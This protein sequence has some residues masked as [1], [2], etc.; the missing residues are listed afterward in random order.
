M[1]RP[2][3]PLILIF[4]ALISLILSA[5]LKQTPVVHQD[6]HSTPAP[7]IH[8][9]LTDTA[10]EIQSMWAQLGRIEQ[11][12]DPGRITNLKEYPGGEV[13]EDLRQELTLE[14]WT[15]EIGVLAKALANKISYRYAELGNKPTQPLIVTITA[16]DQPVGEL[17]RVG[18]SGR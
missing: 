2:R 12:R 11:S 18:L 9:A 16:E 8:R 4:C 10:L 7:D 6:S 13:P 17:L 14:T 3:H 15:G 5:C 1:N